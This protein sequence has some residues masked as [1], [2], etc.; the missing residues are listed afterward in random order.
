MPRSSW[1]RITPEFPRAPMRDPWAMALQVV[2]MSGSPA[3]VSPASSAVTDSRVSAMLVP[4]S[5]SGTGKTLSRLMTCWWARSTS[6]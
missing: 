4:V 1:E 6:R 5:P 3:S 2:A